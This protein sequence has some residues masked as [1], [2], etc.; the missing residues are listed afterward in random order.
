MSSH[1]ATGDFVLYKGVTPPAPNGLAAPAP[2]GLAAPAP[3]I[4]N[5]VAANRPIPKAPVEE[6]LEEPMEER[7]KPLKPF[8]NAPVV[9]QPSSIRIE[10][11]NQD[12]KRK[13]LVPFNS[14]FPLFRFQKNPTNP[15]KRSHGEFHSFK[16]LERFLQRLSS[17]T[18]QAKW[19]HDTFTGAKNEDILFFSGEEKVGS[20]QLRLSDS[21]DW[22]NPSAKRY[23][24]LDLIQFKDAS[25]FQKVQ[26]AIRSFFMELRAAPL[27]PSRKRSQ[28]RIPN[29]RTQ[30]KKF[31]PPRRH[32]HR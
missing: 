10:I 20:I 32:L 15:K 12:P 24:H 19:V 22:N 31:D 8:E 14:V 5:L 7:M 1:S 2:N 29:R 18:V 27:R 13:S 28:K 23:V 30:K 26:D 3:S 6:E 21:N 16:L 17:S 25:L 9:A 4:I 11:A